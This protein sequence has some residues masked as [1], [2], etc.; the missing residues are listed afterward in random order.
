M[1]IGEKV[2]Y[3]SLIAYVLAGVGYLRVGEG[4]GGE[5]FVETQEAFV[6][7]ESY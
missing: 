7:T 4:A 3:L 6:I 1:G 2:D 5:S